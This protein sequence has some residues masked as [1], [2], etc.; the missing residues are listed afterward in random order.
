M[1]R[2]TLI[3]VLRRAY[4]IAQLSKKSRVPADEV[5]DM[6]AIGH[7]RFPRYSRRRF[8]KGGCFLAGTALAWGVH[9]RSKPATA[10]SS[11]SPV[12]VVGAGL[13]GLTV[14]YRLQQAGVPVEVIEARNTVGG[15]VRTTSVSLDI[16]ASGQSS[17]T[18]SVEMGGEK[19]NS[20]H[21]YIQ[22]LASELD[23]ELIDLLETQQGLTE[24]T[25][26]FEGRKVPMSQL[27]QDFM[28]IAS[29]IDADLEAIENFESYDVFDPPTVE[30]D[31]ISL[32]GYLDQIPSDA[33]MRNIIKV[34]YTAEYGLDSEEQSCLN[35]LWYI[36]TE[37]GE[38][39]IFGSSDER[40]HI[41]GG[42]ELLPQ[43]LARSLDASIL[44]GTVLE[45]IREQADG[46]YKVT[47]RTSINSHER[48]YER[49]VLALPFSALRDVAMVMD[50]PIAKRL[51]I[52]DLENATNAKLITAYRDR[53]WVNRYN[54]TA[55]MFTDTG[56]QNAWESSQG[57][58]SEGTASLVTNFAGGRHGIDIE[59]IAPQASAQDFV[60]QFDQIFPGVADSHYTRQAIR[61]T[62]NRDPYSK[63]S[64][65]C[66]KVGDWT[67]FYNAP[68][69]R[70]GN[71]FFIGEHC[72]W[73]YAGYMEG[74]CETGELAAL[75][76]LDE[77]GLSE[78]AHLQKQRV[79][80][81]QHLHRHTRYQRPFH[82]ARLNHQR[83]QAMAK[84]FRTMS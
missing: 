13:A 12:L 57:T 82:Q 36:G 37:P 17:Q 8:L 70:V 9:Q 27:V 72:S 48:M 51:A 21:A 54:S 1:S 74:A 42:N 45:A 56:F 7:R 15:R 5:V 3:N 49:V 40:Y 38:F 80:T 84:R 75:E 46:R 62:W 50:L 30:L 18:L 19:I 20:D 31:N 69:E 39:S 63:G 78:A 55:A 59:R 33:T 26:F 53:T 73:E 43:T 64:Y 4:W 25:F 24:E 76:L 52:A 29:R 23:L 68:A 16:P 81:A 32:A 10:Q 58:Y 77:L 65:S 66:Y 61:S 35:L 47:M 79:T 14:A 44:T 28:P 34:A 2:S 41:K 71:L 67:R 6:V 60:A 83:L 22:A 11:I